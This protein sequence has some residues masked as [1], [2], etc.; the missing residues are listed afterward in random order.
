MTNRKSH[1]GFRLVPQS[2]TLNDLERRSGPCF[3]VQPNYVAFVEDRP[4]MSTKYRLLVT[5]GH[6]MQQSH[7]LVATAK[8]LVKMP[9][10]LIVC[11]WDLSRNLKWLTVRLLNHLMKRVLLALNLTRIA[12]RFA[13]PIYRMCKCELRTSRL[14]KVYIV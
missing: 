1:T 10:I 12:W 2:V 4:K 7:G 8:L 3:A 11:R 14:S 9:F 5:F 6:L 13:H